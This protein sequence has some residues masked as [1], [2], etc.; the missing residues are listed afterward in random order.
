[1]GSSQKNLCGFTSDLQRQLWPLDGAMI[2]KKSCDGESLLSF[3][4]VTIGS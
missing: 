1:M 2:Y 3:F 4:E